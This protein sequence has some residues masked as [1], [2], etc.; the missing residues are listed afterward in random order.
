MDAPRRPSV[1]RNYYALKLDAQIEGP[2]IRSGAPSQFLGCSPLDAEH[3]PPREPKLGVVVVNRLVGERR[4]NRCFNRDL[5]VE[6]TRLRL[7]NVRCEQDDV[8]RE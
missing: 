1:G 5:D 8:N 3:L 7:A 6:R 4:P 2:P